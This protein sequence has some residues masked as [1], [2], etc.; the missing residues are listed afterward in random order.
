MAKGLSSPYGVL[1]LHLQDFREKEKALCILLICPVP[2]LLKTRFG[3]NKTIANW[4]KNKM[5]VQL[6][7]STRLCRGFR[8]HWSPLR[9]TSPCHQTKVLSGL[10]LSAIHDYQDNIHVLS[11]V[12]LV[13][14]HIH[15]SG[16]DRSRLMQRGYSLFGRFSQLSFRCRRRLA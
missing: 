14:M 15:D 3:K 10:Y 6:C 13:Y 7:D 2:C 5:A 12:Y 1:P 16:P 8:L 4:R 11:F 9:G